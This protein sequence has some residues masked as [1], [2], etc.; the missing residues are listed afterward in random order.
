MQIDFAVVADYAIIDQNGKLSVLGIFSHIWVGKF[1]ALHP[2]AHLVLHL[3]GRRTEIG[4]HPIGIRLLDEDGTEVLTGQGTVNFNEP[5]AGVLEISAG[6]ILIFDLPFKQ[7]GRYHFEIRLD[8]EVLAE[9]PLTV[10]QHPTAPSA[11]GGAS[12]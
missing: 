5:P 11:P 12:P 4:Q 10:A 2:R 1:P 7:P 9:I 3:K 6:S 8:D